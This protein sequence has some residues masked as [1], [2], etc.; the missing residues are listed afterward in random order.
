MCFIMVGT[1]KPSTKKVK[2]EILSTK[3]KQINDIAHAKSFTYFIMNNTSIG[4]SLSIVMESIY[5][6]KILDTNQKVIK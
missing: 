3:E 5:P 6:K 2:N 4:K 1:F